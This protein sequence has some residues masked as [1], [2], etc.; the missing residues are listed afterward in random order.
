LPA[1]NEI[2]AGE[3]WDADDDGFYL[4]IEE[5]WAREYNYQVGDTMTFRIAGVEATGEIAN[6][7]KVDWES[8]QVN[9]F[10]VASPAL[11]KEFPATFVSSF[12]LSDNFSKT[13]SSWAREFPGIA[14]LDI[15]AIVARIKTLMDRA[16]MAVEYVFLF[17]LLAGTCVLLAAV[18]SSQGERIRESALL[19]ALGAS[20]QQVRHAIVSEFA[21]LGLIAGFLA[22]LFATLIAW[23]LSR[24]VFELPFT[25]NPS[26]WFFGVVGGAVGISI[27]GYLATRRVLYTPPIV[28][29]RHSA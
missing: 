24:E 5:E 16:S 29:L 4:S 13:T 20:H 12:Y 8:F 6:L 18:Q 25:V 9:F 28:A 3:W 22:A 19:R 10:V 11:L 21:I 14:T 7:R 26:L 1:A 27:A 15:G 2:V 17:T 23:A